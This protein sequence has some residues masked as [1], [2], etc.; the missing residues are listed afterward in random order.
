MSVQVIDKRFC[1]L[2]IGYCQLYPDCETYDDLLWLLQTLVQSLFK[3][4]YNHSH[5]LR[6]H[7]RQL[8][9]AMNLQ[10]KRDSYF[11]N[12]SAIVSNN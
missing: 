6:G 8:H 9:L 1:Y 10:V 12:W 5:S 3:S 2:L 11:L 4:V 7:Y